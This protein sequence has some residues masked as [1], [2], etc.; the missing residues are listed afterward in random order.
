MQSARDGGHHRFQEK[1]AVSPTTRPLALVTGASSGIGADLAREL[2]RDGHDLV[3]TARRRQPMQALAQELLAHGARTIV[4]AADLSQPGAAAQLFND[5]TARGFSIDVL[6]N[7]AGLGAQGRFIESAPVRI[8]DMLQ[9]NVVALTELTRLLLPAMVAKGCG[10]VMLVASVA[11]FQPGP[12]WP[13]TS[14]PKLTKS[15]IVPTGPTQFDGFSGFFAAPVV[16]RRP[17]TR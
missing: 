3:L 6:I 17:M 12:Q 5:L 4:I 15:P 8:N 11:S 16:A 1:S 14:R 10:R 13:S 7:N 2:A 9:V